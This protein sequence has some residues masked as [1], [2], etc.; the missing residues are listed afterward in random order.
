MNLLVGC[1]LDSLRGC[2]IL[3]MSGSCLHLQRPDLTP[4]G[5]MGALVFSLIRTTLFVIQTPALQRTVLIN[6]SEY[7]IIIPSAEKLINGIIQK[8]R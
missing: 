7:S 3:L 8:K 5:R 4:Q 6:R 1:T 2:K